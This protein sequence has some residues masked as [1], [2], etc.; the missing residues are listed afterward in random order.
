MV[1]ATPSFSLTTKLSPI[2]SGIGIFFNFFESKIEVENTKMRPVWC[3]V[4][5]EK[6]RFHNALSPA[7]DLN[8]GCLC[9][10]FLAIE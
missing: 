4:R 7:C 10:V 3:S 1:A 2:L 8:A 6:A 9:V 5:R